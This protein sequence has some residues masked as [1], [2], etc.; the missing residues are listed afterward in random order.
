MKFFIDECL[1]PILAKRLNERGIDA[2]HPLNVGRRGEQDHTVLTRCLEEDRILVTENA[3]D[4]RRLIGRVE[5]HP[6]LV[7]LPSIDREGTWRLLN[8]VLDFLDRQEKPRDYMFNRVLEVS[9]DGTIIACQLP[10]LK[11]DERDE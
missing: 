4:F 6:G 9:E 11:G 2:F 5:M 7:V 1:S 3:Q 8:A 10:P